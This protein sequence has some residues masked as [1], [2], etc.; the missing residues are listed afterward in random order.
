MWR[1]R[2]IALAVLIPVAALTLS[3][4]AVSMDSLLIGLM[5]SIMVSLPTLVLMRCLLDPCR[6]RAT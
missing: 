5:A 3:S 4:V 1:K 2:A 6:T